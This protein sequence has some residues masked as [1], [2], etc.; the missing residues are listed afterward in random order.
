MLPPDGRSVAVS[1]EQLLIKDR[2]GNGTQSEVLLAELP[3]GCGLVAV[4][5]GL[6]EHAISRE[7]AVQL[8]MSGVAGF[9]TMLHYEL[10]GP[11]CPPGGFLLADLLGASLH[12]LLKSKRD[13]VGQRQLQLSGQALTVVGRGV[14]RPLRELHARGFVHNDV[15]PGNIL[16]GDRSPVQP[17]QLYLIDFG[18]CS[19]AAGHTPPA[20]FEEPASG[21]RATLSWLA[22]D[23]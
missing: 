6:R 13:L 9:P 7:V 5:V 21:A 3:G 14:L 15:K 20:D 11:Y 23:R 2:L 8:F 4:K 1:I 10:E 22:V 17:S 16:L 19:T 18:S 12:Q